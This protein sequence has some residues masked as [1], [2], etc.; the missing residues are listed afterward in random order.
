MA[1][2][3]ECKVYNEDRDDIWINLDQV[4]SIRAHG[5]GSALTCAAAGDGV[6]TITVWDHPGDILAQKGRARA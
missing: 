3:V 5:T 2:W 4:I 1:T 6:H